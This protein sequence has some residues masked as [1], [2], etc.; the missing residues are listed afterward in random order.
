M[1]QQD[2]AG[3]ATPKSIR[4]REKIVECAIALFDRHGYAN[5]SLDDIAKEVGI[6]REGIYYYF[7]NRA[8]ILLSIILPQSEALIDGLAEIMIADLPPIERLHRAVR[9]HLERFDVHCLEMTVSL[10]DG[11]FEDAVEVRDVMNRIWK[12]Y[13]RMWTTL[14]ADGQAS[15]A[16]RDCGDPKML[17]FG[18][19]GMCNWLARWYD[20]DKS[21]SIPSLI[22]SYFDMIAFGL[23]AERGGEAGK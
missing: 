22:E 21:V 16:F 14:I 15:G 12:D 5:T 11:Y 23:A 10:R 13:E 8:E 9:N 2:R 17:A 19:L 1:A 18:I 7:K 6:K 20:P 3:A 4:R